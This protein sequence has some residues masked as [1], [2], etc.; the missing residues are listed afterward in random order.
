MESAKGDVDRG[1]G[2]GSPV[3]A[4]GDSEGNPFSEVLDLS[5]PL[6]L[7]FL[8]FLITSIAERQLSNKK[9]KNWGARPSSYSQFETPPLSTLAWA[10]QG[11]STPGQS[12]FTPLWLSFRSGCLPLS[13]GDPQE[14]LHEN[15][16]ALGG[17][18][19]QKG[20]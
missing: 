10:P 9:S 2:A 15:L 3:R 7:C 12:P 13:G 1:A 18:N 6:L 20:E 8:C 14:L 16:M 5:T 11:H 19:G 17:H 4:G